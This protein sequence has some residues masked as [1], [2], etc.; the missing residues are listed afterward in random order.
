MEHIDD[1]TPDIIFM[2]QKTNKDKNVI[3]LPFGINDFYNKQ[4][5]NNKDR[6]KNKKHYYLE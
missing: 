3:Y 2:I 4:F 5:T 6:N 1:Y